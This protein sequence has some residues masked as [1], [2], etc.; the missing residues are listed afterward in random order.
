M[1]LLC[2]N[3]SA[4]S[5]SKQ[6]FELFGLLVDGRICILYVL[7]INKIKL[8]EGA[9]EKYA[10]KIISILILILSKEHK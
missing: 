9:S 4:N 2:N 5:W 1:I 10:L 8:K 3:S 6:D 7:K